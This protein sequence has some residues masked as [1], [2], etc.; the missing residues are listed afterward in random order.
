MAFGASA[1][2]MGCTMGCDV[3]VN[4]VYGIS[5]YD[6]WIIYQFIG[7]MSSN[8]E[9]RKGRGISSMKD[10]SLW[11]LPHCDSEIGHDRSYCW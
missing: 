9:H 10:F 4:M 1:L 11:S 6:A 2:M 8:G 3:G 5:V 7:L